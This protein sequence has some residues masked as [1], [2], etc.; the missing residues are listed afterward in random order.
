MSENEK[1]EYHQWLTRRGMWNVEL[2]LQN[3]EREHKLIIH[4]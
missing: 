3:L 4:S 2:I 1:M